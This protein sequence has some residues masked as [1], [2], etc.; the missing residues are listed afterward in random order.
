MPLDD[1]EPLGRS[2]RV[3]KSGCS[4]VVGLATRD[5]QR[6][7]TAPLAMSRQVPSVSIGSMCRDELARRCSKMRYHRVYTGP[8]A[9][10][11]LRHLVRSQ[12]ID[13]VMP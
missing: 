5:L 1:T 4:K 10:M 11:F 9:M 12:A 6:G 7:D 8:T 2:A 3:T 13:G